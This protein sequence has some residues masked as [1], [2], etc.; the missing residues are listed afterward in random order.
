[1]DPIRGYSFSKGFGLR[2]A[3]LRLIEV[4]ATFEQGIEDYFPYSHL[5]KQRMLQELDNAFLI[6]NTT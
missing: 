3:A 1:M 5:D 4:N 6:R 2:E